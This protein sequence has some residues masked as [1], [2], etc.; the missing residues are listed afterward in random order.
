[1]PHLVLC[2]HSE[3]RSEAKYRVCILVVNRRSD[4]LNLEKTRRLAQSFTRYCKWTLENAMQDA[5]A[6]TNP[7]I[8]QHVAQIPPQRRTLPPK[9]LHALQEQ[10]ITVKLP[11]ALHI[12]DEMILHPPKLHLALELLMPEALPAHCVPHR[13][14]YHGFLLPDFQLRF[15]HCLL[16]LCGNVVFGDVFEA[17]NAPREA[18]R[19]F[20]R[21]VADDGFEDVDGRE[22]TVCCCGHGAVFCVVGAN[23][24]DGVESHVD[25]LA[26]SHLGEEDVWVDG[27]DALTVVEV[28]LMS[29]LRLVDHVFGVDVVVEVELIG[30]RV[31]GFAVGVVGAFHAEFEDDGVDIFWFFLLTDVGIG[32]EGWVVIVVFE[33]GDGAGF[34]RHPSETF[35]G[36]GEGDETQALGEDFVLDDGGVVLNVDTLD[37]EGGDFVDHDAPEGVGNGG[38]HA[39]E[40]ESGFAVVIFVE[41]DPEILLESGQ[42]PC[43]VFAWIMVG[44]VC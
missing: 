24:L 34:V 35:E 37:G 4:D 25:F 40:G 32:A 33:A 12:E 41:L 18:A 5:E 13:V 2:Q 6:T 10:P 31:G 44:E 20:D 3:R 30:F 16:I 9:N 19:E 38:V 8:P 36:A 22:Q 43:V 29:A 7:S 27:A 26:G 17:D 39:D 14:P 28:L 42:G 11:C 21:V 23:T 15:R 1:M